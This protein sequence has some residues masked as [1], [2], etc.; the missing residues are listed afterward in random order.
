[1]ALAIDGD[2]FQD[3]YPVSLNPES[4]IYLILRSAAADSRKP[5]PHPR[6]NQIPALVSE[7]EPTGAAVALERHAEMVRPDL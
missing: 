7:F 3:A 6:L 4:E 5:P 2:I 1:M